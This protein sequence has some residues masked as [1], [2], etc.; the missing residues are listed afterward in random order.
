MSSGEYKGC[1][2]DGKFRNIVLNALKTGEHQYSEEQ[3]SYGVMIVDENTGNIL[4]E[5][6][7]QRDRIIYPASSIKTLV[8]MAVLRKVDLGKITLDDNVTID[9]SNAA[10]ECSDWDCNVY[11]PGKIVKIN[12]LL[13]DMITVSN[14]IATNQLIDVASKPFINEISALMGVPEMKIVRKLWATLD[15]EPNVPGRNSAS[16]FTLTQMYREIS[17]GY[18][19]ILSDQSRKYLIDLLKNQHLNNRL[20]AEFPPEI[21][22]YHKTGSTSFSSS[23]AGFYYLKPGVIVM[24]SGL[25]A[26]K[27][28]VPLAKI[29]KQTLDLTL[30]FP[31]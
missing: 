13:W 9:Q 25:Q 18:Q 6:Y 26:F 12:K 15:P 22:F 21:V 23:D 7:V 20:N 4:C 27:D 14:N 11:G 3:T 31:F 30:G 2:I 10:A 5:E 16:A 8:A 1:E 17:T 24:L 28:Y 29:G 19:H